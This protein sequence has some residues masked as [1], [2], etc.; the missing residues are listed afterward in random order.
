MSHM[1]N[2]GS[3]LNDD[4][5]NN[6]LKKGEKLMKTKHKIVNIEIVRK[7]KGSVPII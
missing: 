4:D 1:S 3:S 6:D 5:N 2:R 7:R